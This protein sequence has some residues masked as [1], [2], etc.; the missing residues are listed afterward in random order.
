MSMSLTVKQKLVETICT[1]PGVTIEPHRFGGTA[2]IYDGKEIAHLH[3]DHHLDISFSKPIRDELIAAGRAKSHHI[4]PASGWVTIYIYS[5]SE[6]THAIDLLRMKY[7][8]L[9]MNKR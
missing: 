3:G 9:A 4:F 8:R 5:E 7:D 2:F 1:W 6:L